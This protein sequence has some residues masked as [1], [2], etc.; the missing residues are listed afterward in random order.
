[1]ETFEEKLEEAQEALGI[2][3]HK[4]VP[5]TYSSQT[6]WVQEVMRFAPT[7][8]LLGTLY[9]LSQR[10]Q[11]GSGGMGGP[12]GIFSIGKAQVTKLDK[13]SKNKACFFF[14]FFAFNEFII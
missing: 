7:L 12:R 11:V 5:V 9:F 4:Y 10:M 2:D 6:N 3:P 8:L 1:M 13:N 14:L